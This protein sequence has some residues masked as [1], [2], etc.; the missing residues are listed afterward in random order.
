LV[1]ESSPVEPF[2]VVDVPVIER[3]EISEIKA[4]GGRVR[5]FI[6]DGPEITA[7]LRGGNDN[8]KPLSAHAFVILKRDA[9]LGNIT[10][11]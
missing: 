4:V 8:P 10:H 5:Q 2:N 7:R 3:D 11:F 1:G 9:N 6:V